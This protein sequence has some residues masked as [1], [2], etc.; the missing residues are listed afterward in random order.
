MVSLATLKC[1]AQVVTDEKVGSLLFIRV[2][3]LWSYTQTDW[4]L[5]K[6]VHP[7]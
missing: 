6:Y 5:F 1:E 3:V 4:E 2:K 7:H